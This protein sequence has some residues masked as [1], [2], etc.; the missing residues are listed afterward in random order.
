MCTLFKYGQLLSKRFISRT[1]FDF[2]SKL[3]F[4]TKYY[5]NQFCFCRLHKDFDFCINRNCTLSNKINNKK[6][7]R[8][9]LNDP[10]FI[11]VIYYYLL[12][13]FNLA[14]CKVT[15]THL[16]RARKFWNHCPCGIIGTTHTNVQIIELTTRI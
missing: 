1:N 3:K 7:F 10:F 15:N 16:H 2:D 14:N 9:E 12:N 4:D 8:I 11:F 5:G 6:L 13:L